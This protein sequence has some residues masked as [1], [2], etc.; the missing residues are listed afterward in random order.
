MSISVEGPAWSGSGGISQGVGQRVVV[1][2]RYG[3]CRG[4]CLLDNPLDDKWFVLN[5]RGEATAFPG[6]VRDRIR[7]EDAAA[8]VDQADDNPEEDQDNDREL[9]E[10]LPT[11]AGVVHGP[12]WMMAPH[13][14]SG[15]TWKAGSDWYWML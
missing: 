13:P 5:N 4:L 3:R 14:P 1:G 10:S 6:G 9:N 2:H 7:D 11:A 15:L 12:T 8:E